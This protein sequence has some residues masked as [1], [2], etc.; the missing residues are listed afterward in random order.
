MFPGGFTLPRVVPRRVRQLRELHSRWNCRR[1]MHP[2]CTPLTCGVL[3]PGYVIPDRWLGE[4]AKIYEPSMVAFSK[5]PRSCIGINLAY[6]ELYLVI[7]G[8]FRRFDVTLDAERS[9]DMSVVEHFV[10]VFR[11]PH[12]HAY[13][14]P[15]LD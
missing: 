2:S 10:P 13:C 14:K 12:L 9:G 11:G 5:G 15:V 4:G 1:S 8:I 3:Q 6:C 7:A